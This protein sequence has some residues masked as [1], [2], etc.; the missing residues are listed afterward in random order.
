MIQQVKSKYWEDETGRSIP[1]QYITPSIR[2]RERHSALI[3]KGAES[4]NKQL[5]AFKK[6]VV[7]LCDEVFIKAMEEKSANKETKGNFTW[8]NFDRSIKIEVSIN[9]R[10]DFDDL[11][12]KA[13]KDKLDDFLEQSLDSKTAFVKN[14]VMDAFSTSRG[15]L[16]AKK[17]MA[18]TKYRK[19]IKDPLFQEALDLMEESIRRPDSKTYFRVWK[20]EEDGSYKLI[21]LNFSSI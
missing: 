7:K 13:C 2:Q 16:D 9:E 4:L 3:L 8:F 15:K 10:I 6:N 11:T 18:L 1:V 5:L 14:L 19:D 17:V 20:R 21:D 12:I